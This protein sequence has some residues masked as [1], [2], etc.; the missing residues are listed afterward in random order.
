MRRAAPLLAALVA[1]VF[2]SAASA[3]TFKIVAPGADLPSHET[4]NTPGSI[5]VP[6]ALSTPP[7][8]PEKRSYDELLSLWRR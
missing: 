5:V 7:S 1:A 6:F 8:R 2:A 4:P 3:Q